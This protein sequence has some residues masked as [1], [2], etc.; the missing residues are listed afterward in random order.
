[1]IDM[2]LP[3][4]SAPTMLSDV[5]DDAYP[6]GMKFEVEGDQLR[7]LGI[8]SGNLPQVGDRMTMNAQVEV[9]EVSKED[10]AIEP[11]YCVCFQIQ[12]MQFV[13]KEDAMNEQQAAHAKI[14]GMYGD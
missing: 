10:G 13:S 14:A 2:K 12:G 11:S 4:L 7:A 9:V 1:M 6:P 5:A 3:P 8:G